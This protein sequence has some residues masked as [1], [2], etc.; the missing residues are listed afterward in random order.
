[1]VYNISYAGFSFPAGKLSDRIGARTVILIGYLVL[2]S[3]YAVLG[4]AQTGFVLGLGF[5][6]LGLFPALTDGVQRSL[7][8]QLT[9]KDIRG[10]GLGWLNAS[11][12]FG[13]LLAGIGGGY[14]WQVYSPAAAFLAA[15]FVVAVGLVLFLVSASLPAADRG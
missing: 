9:A 8:A 4:P 12:G 5:L 3:S 15:S 10:A 11:N 7:A 6:I 2:I 1:M 13:A 14:L